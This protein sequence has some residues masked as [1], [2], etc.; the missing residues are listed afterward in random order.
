L[1]KGPGGFAFEDVNPSLASLFQREELKYR[2]YIFS[3]YPK[4]IQ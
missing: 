3:S 1:K 2:D 4:G